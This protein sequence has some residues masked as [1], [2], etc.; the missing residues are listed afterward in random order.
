M[1]NVLV[2]TDFSA[3]AELASDLGIKIARRL[4]TGVTFLHLL[5]TPVEW[6][7]LP[8]E[9]EKLYPET[10]AAIGEAKDKLFNLERRTEDEGVDAHTSLI[11]NLGIEE[12]YRYINQENYSLV[13]MGTHGEKG[14]HKPVGS[15][16]LKVIHK[17]PV[18]V[19]AAR[20]GEKSEVPLQ[21]VIIS[22][23]ME[24][25]RESFS[26]LMDLATKLD[27]S[28]HLLYLNTP[29]FFI[30]TMEINGK[31]KEFLAPYSGID[32]KPI[33]INSFNEER[34]LDYYLQS[35]DCDLVSVIIHGPSGLN[36]FFRRSIVERILN[37][38]DLPIM[39]I[40]ADL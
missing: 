30:E 34:G 6:R 10:K 20:S 22:D 26:K 8:L 28:V 39:S 24:K 29:D 15:N 9:K 25:S 14:S 35:Y 40:N 5:S 2:L 13:V 31:F 36:P 17:S 38:L 1:K 16:T 7:N 21:W 27:A 19:I 18:P 4:N 32:I 11:F 23:F 37:Q 33:I 12:I 3:N